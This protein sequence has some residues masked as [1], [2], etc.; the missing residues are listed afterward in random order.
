MALPRE[1]N[2]DLT[3]SPGLSL[4]FGFYKDWQ[5]NKPAQNFARNYGTNSLP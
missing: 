3:L 1:S 5:S 2:L 4:V